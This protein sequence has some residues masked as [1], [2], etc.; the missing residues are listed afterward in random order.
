MIQPG[1]VSAAALSVATSEAIQRPEPPRHLTPEE[2]DVW[3]QTTGAVRV[4]WF[5]K[6]V[7]LVLETY[8]AIAVAIRRTNQELRGDLEAMSPEKYRRL[9]AL[10]IKQ[11]GILSNLAT[12]LRIT[13]K[14]TSQHANKHKGVEAEGGGKIW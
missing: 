6:E 8:C 13:N 1:R 2:R 10:Q 7:L 12:R 3:V 4:D 5:K 14:S 11:A 9:T